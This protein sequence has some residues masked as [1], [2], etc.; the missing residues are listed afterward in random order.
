MIFI[1]EPLLVPRPRRIEAS[2]DGPRGALSD[3]Y[4]TGNQFLD[5]RSISPPNCV[6]VATR[7]HV[8]GARIAPDAN[9]SLV[10]F[11]YFVGA[12]SPAK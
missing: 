3:G 10:G 5:E 8:S 12:A 2:T 6:A 11:S 4:E 7:T 9:F 1:T